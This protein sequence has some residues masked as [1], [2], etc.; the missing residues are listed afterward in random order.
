V[1]DPLVDKAL[2]DIVAGL[3]GRRLDTGQLPL[4]GATLDGVGEQVCRVLGAYQPLPGESDGD[5]GS[6][7]GDPPPPPLFRD[8]RGGRRAA[9]RIKHQVP[10]IGA[11]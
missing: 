10:R 1:R 4:L 9:G 7:D 5:A 6:V 11:H 8:V 3:G 2:S